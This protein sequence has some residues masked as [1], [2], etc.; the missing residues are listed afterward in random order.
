MGSHIEAVDNA[1][2]G[3]SIS[4]NRLLAPRAVFGAV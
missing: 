1:V 2:L 4:H 3:R